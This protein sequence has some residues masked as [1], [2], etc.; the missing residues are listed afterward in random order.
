LLAVVLPLFIDVLLL[1]IDVAIVDVDD[2]CDEF[3]AATVISPI[4]PPP[5]PNEEDDPVRK[6]RFGGIVSGRDIV[7][8]CCRPVK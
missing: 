8:A 5:T 7:T 2:D 1:F 3:V 4:I 6:W